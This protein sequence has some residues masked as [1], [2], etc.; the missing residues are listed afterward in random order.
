MASTWSFA[1]RYISKCTCPW[2]SS[3]NLSCI[4]SSPSFSLSLHVPVC[5]PAAFTPTSTFIGILLT[6]PLPPSPPP[7]KPNSP[8]FPHFLDTIK[9]Y[10]FP[11]SS[12]IKTRLRQNFDKPK[13]QQTSS[14]TETVTQMTNSV[15][16]YTEE[17]PFSSSAGPLPVPFAASIWTV[18][19]NEKFLRNRQKKGSKAACMIMQQQCAR[20]SCCGCATDRPFRYGMARH[21][22]QTL[23]ITGLVQGS[24]TDFSGGLYIWPL[25]FRVLRYF[26]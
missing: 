26:H 19:A 2:S 23:I 17:A 9:F 20:F 12:T 13:Q 5:L 25:G 24:E 8:Q 6:P 4:P 21:E 1:L 14:S 10:L 16:L 7:P 15:L 22:L 3:T 11:L 18:N